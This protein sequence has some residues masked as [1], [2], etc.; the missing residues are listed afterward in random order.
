MLPKNRG[1]YWQQ[2]AAGGAPS[3]PPPAP[4]PAAPPAPEPAPQDEPF[5][6]ARAMATIS[7][8]R[9]FEKQAKAQ[10]KELETLRTQQREREEAELSEQGKLAKRAERAEAEAAVLKGQLAS[11]Q[12]RGAVAEAATRLGFVDVDAAARLL[13][14]DAVQRD[15]ATGEV[16]GR[17]LRAAL[18]K[19]GRD[20]PWL[21]NKEAAAQQAEAQRAESRVNSRG[22]PATPRDRA[23]A[24]PDPVAAAEQQYRAGVGGVRY[25]R[26]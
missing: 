22:L 11:M 18:E 3:D 12:F 1:V 7:K 25:G 16:D 21:L 2:D 13:D 23:A 24:P 10:G 14:A 6:A 8:L 17:S 26:F 5:D 9:E 19:M 20:R 4:A 15:D